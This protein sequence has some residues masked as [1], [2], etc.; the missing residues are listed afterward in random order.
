V[1]VYEHIP[2]CER[3]NLSFLDYLDWKRMN[4][5]LS[6]LELYVGCC[7]VYRH[8]RKQILPSRYS[9]L[10]QKSIK[11]RTHV[12][13]AMKA[14][15]ERQGWTQAILAQILG[16]GLPSVGRLEATES[17]TGLT[18]ARLHGLAKAAGEPL[19]AGIFWRALEKEAETRPKTASLIDEIREWE[20]L[21]QAVRDLAKEVRKLAPSDVTSRIQDR[22]LDLQ[23]AYRIVRR[24]R[25][26]ELEKEL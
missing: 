13:L 9:E 23:M 7:N 10:M 22:E 17:P 8:G 3:C 14:L 6:S 5:T 24:L 12:Q 2:L 21:D 4:K 19:L 25:W 11:R 1:G 15:R 26:K 16:M 20:I 18:L